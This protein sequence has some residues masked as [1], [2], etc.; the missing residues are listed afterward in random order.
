M[1]SVFIAAFLV[2][3]LVQ[4][5]ELS[6]GAQ[7]YAAFLERLRSPGWVL[8]HVV[9]LLAALY[10][11][12]TWFN[13]TP[14]A[15]VIRLGEERVSPVLIAGINYLIWLVLSGGVVWIVLGS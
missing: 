12:I 11:S 8:F 5:F 7:A 14:K 4:L 1:T 15:I 2:L 13:L 6:R 10:H 9:A 3:Y